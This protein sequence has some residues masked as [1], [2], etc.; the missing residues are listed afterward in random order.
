MLLRFLPAAAFALLSVPAHA[1]PLTTAQILNQFNTVVLGSA[2]STSHTDGRTYIGGALSGGDYVQHVNQ[3]PASDYAGLTVR[4]STTGV[5]V[6]GLGTVVGGSLTNSTVNSGSS[7]V[8]GGAVNDSFNG[9]AYVEG[10]A[11]GNFNGGKASTPTALMQTNLDAASS[12][13][14]GSALGALANSL[15][16]LASTG[17]SVSFSGNRAIFDAKVSGDGVAVF[18][19]SAIDDEL[20][21]KGEFVFNLN[22]ASTV[23]LNTDIKN[24]NIS[25]NFLGG[26]AQQYGSNLLWN[27]YDAASLTINSQWGGSLLATGAS[28]TNNQN[29]EGGVYVN[30]LTQRGEIHLDQ[31]SGTLPSAGAIRPPAFI[32]EPGSIALML[33]GLA[34]ITLLA[35]RRRARAG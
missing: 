17:S 25:A 8:K 14:F 12:T 27:F 20:F 1:V 5:K 30:S 34:A 3:T 11:S 23:I 22:G 15:K 35:R 10:G 32:P 9:L 6:N 33:T 28:L 18:D 7:V 19:L 26:S 21:S 2:T 29:I 13:D 24:A 16:S 31:F 4:G